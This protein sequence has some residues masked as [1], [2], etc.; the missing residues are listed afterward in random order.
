ML[1][2]Y[3]SHRAFA[4]IVSIY[5]A[6]LT[7]RQ[8]AHQVV[9]SLKDHT[10]DQLANDTYII[11]G[12]NAYQEP[13]LPKKIIVVQLEQSNALQWFGTIDKPSEYI[14]NLA[15]VQTIWDYSMNNCRW[16]KQYFQH[17]AHITH[18]IVRYA[19]MG[20][21][22][23][24]QQPTTA[25]KSIDILF[26][27]AMNDRRM[28]LLQQLVNHPRRPNVHIY[29]DVWGYKKR[30]LIRQAKFLIN[31]HYYPQ[32]ILETVRLVEV[33]SEGTYVISETS[34]DKLLD[35]IYGNYITLCSYDKLITTA[36]TSLDNWEHNP[37]PYIQKVRRFQQERSMEHTLD[38]LFRSI[39]T[40]VAQNAQS[41][42]NLP[43]AKPLE[44]APLQSIPKI[45]VQKSQ[46]EEILIKLPHLGQ[47]LPKV[48]VV[49]ITR[50]RPQFIPLMVY[51]WININYPRDKLEWIIVDDSIQDY[52]QELF[53]QLNTYAD[54]D[55]GNIKYTHSNTIYEQLGIKRNFAVEQAT[56]D[57]I[58]MMDDDDLYYPDS[59][60]NR[61][62][63]LQ[64]SRCVGV[65]Q[66]D[67]YDTNHQGC[68]RINS[69][70]ISEASMAFW[71]SFWRERPFPVYSPFKGEGIPFIV[72]RES[73]VITLPSCFVLLAITHKT[74][75][76]GDLRSDPDK[77]GH[78]EYLHLVSQEALDIVRQCTNSHAELPKNKVHK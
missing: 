53:A 76:T 32:A 61:V 77:R 13:Y 48:S 4:Y 28:D 15:H 24:C 43:D 71:K 11:I 29:T 45:T 9:C 6:Y 44:L 72:Y 55:T 16:L 19:P 70:G 58:V 75:Y 65:Q 37:Q 35:R 25:N 5:H 63:A 12:F 69:N 73:Q 64:V 40:T 49:T 7:K 52:S 17:H 10:E 1:W 56:G 36:L 47:P 22:L 66:L 41:T 38:T 39:T 67:V 20:A 68:Y 21:H 2:I 60:Y 3:Y 59:V 50:G 18:P 78:L 14:K 54:R 26:I 51:N 57:I 33:L 30:Q 34:S 27:G 62:S 31:I 74:N 42:T 23:I 46:G 8:I